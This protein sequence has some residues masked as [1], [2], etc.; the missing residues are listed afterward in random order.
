MRDLNEK[1]R[2]LHHPA[3]IQSEVV[4]HE[5]EQKSQ[6]TSVKFFSELFQLEFSSGFARDGVIG[7]REGR[8]GEILLLPIGQRPGDRPAQ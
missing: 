5:V 7:D 1:L 4:G 2:P 3:V 6:S 8:A